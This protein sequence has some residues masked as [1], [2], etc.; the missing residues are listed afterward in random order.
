MLTILGSVILAILGVFLA[1]ILIPIVFPE[2]EESLTLIPILSISIIPGT[3]TSMYTSKFLGK[4]K[5]LYVLIG[6]LISAVALVLGILILSEIFGVIGL[7]IAYVG[8]MSLQTIFLVIM[9][10][11]K[12]DIFREK[13]NHE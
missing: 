4:E 7:A 6:Y 13:M 3:I 8:S 9:N 10:Y 1:P 11:F 5:S 2:Y 12:R